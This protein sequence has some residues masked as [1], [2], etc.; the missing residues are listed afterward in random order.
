MTD[1]IFIASF[2]NGHETCTAVFCSPYQ[3]DWEGGI[4]TA[5]RAYR[6]LLVGAIKSIR[7]KQARG[8]AIDEEVEFSKRAEKLLA[9]LPRVI[10]GRFELDDE[11]LEARFL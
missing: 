1:P 11:P 8:E 5:E 6:K 3:L 7:E 2:D 10:Y 9:S 4:K